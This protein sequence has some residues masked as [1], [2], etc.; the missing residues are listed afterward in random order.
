VKTITVDQA[1]RDFN[2]VIEHVERQQEEVALV[3]NRKRIARVVPESASQNAVEIFRDIAGVLSG[4]AGAS[5]ARSVQDVRQGDRG[6][7]R[8]IKNP[9]AS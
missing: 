8:T 5:L 9:W 7:L 4:E 1:Q 2:A 6:R 3:R